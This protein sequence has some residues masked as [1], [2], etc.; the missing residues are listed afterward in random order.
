MVREPLDVR[1][2]PADYR[3]I[4]KILDVVERARTPAD[5]QRLTLEAVDE[6]LGY[7]RSTFFIG[8]P[9][10]PGF[11]RLAGSTR[12]LKQ[13]D[14]EEY[15]ERWTPDD[16]FVSLAATN[17]MRRGALVDLTELAVEVLPNERRYVERFLLRQASSQLSLW[18]D[19]GLPMHGYLSVF[20]TRPT[21]FAPRDRAILLTLRPH[22]AFLLRAILLDGRANEKAGQLSRR[23]AEVGTLVALGCTNREIARHLGIGEDTVKKHL[24]H[25][26]AKLDVRNRTQLA[27]LLRSGI[28]E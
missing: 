11:R 21:E 13:V 3:G 4:L 10:E 7:T 9:P 15:L 1:L 8:D 16:P 14:L 5:F 2:E 26:M 19:T 25:A 12:G 17:R 28:R 18:L 24:L 20:G 27:L 22:L 6:H 23:E